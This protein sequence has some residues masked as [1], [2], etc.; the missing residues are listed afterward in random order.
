MKQIDEQIRQARSALCLSQRELAQIAGVSSVSVS[1][2]ENGK[3]GR[4]VYR[5][6]SF[7]LGLGEADASLEAERGE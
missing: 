3:G 1:R 7:A 5:L 6:L 4:L 2:A